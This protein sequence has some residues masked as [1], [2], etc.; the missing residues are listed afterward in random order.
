MLNKVVLIGNLGKDPEIRTMQSGD[1]VANFSLAISERWKDK[2]TNERKEKTE[3][4][5]V[6]VFNQGIVRVIE[7]YVK[8]GSKVYIEGQLETKKWTDQNGVEKYTTEIVLKP[9]KSELVMLDGKSEHQEEPKDDPQTEKEYL[10]KALAVVS[11][12]L[13]EDLEDE[14]PF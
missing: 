10:S 5:K 12:A 6:S 2:T 1:R 4:H 8:K 11:K 13:G 3:W 9:F 7:S 14:I